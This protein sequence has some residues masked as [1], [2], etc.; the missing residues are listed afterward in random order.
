MKMLEEIKKI[1]DNWYKMIKEETGYYNFN[2]KI[3]LLMFVAIVIFL[4]ITFITSPTDYLGTN[5]YLE[6][7]TNVMCENPFYKDNYVT[8]ELYLEQCPDKDLCNIQYF[9]PHTSWGT[10]PTFLFRNSYL[11]IFLIIICALVINH[12]VYNKDWKFEKDKEDYEK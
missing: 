10:P 6:C 3:F 4:A 2:K 8:Q 7:N 5:I 11:I 12:F 9:L 1:N